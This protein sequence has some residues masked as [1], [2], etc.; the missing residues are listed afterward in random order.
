MLVVQFLLSR[1]QSQKYL[2]AIR[3]TII[4]VR[5]NLRQVNECAIMPVVNNVTNST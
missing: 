5:G 2:A 3:Q 1:F 4:K